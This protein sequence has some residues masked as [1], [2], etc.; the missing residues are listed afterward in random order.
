MSNFQVA[1]LIGAAFVA[2]SSWR[3]ER[4][5]LWIMAGA[6]SFA[7]STA[8]SRYGLP[9][10]PLFTA[11][12]DAAV[13][14]AIY[15]GAKQVWELL[16]Y[17]LF[18]ASV[19]ISVVFVGFTIATKTGPHAAYVALLEAI[20]WLALSLILGTAA[21]QRI[22]ADGGGHAFHLGRDIVHWARASLFAPKK[23]HHG[24]LA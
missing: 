22:K 19:L 15:V 14:F 21:M 17:Q 11:C 1:L 4:S 3:L 20:N 13:C 8:W 10:P 9:M 5:L 16:L 6:A 24:W 12:C 2:V 7:A 23:P 18:R